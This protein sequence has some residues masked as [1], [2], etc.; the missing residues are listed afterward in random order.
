M[1]EYGLYNGAWTGP[2]IDAAIGRS[3]QISNPNLLD[4]WYFVGGGSQNGYGKFPINQRRATTYNNITSLQYGADR[5]YFSAGSYELVAQGMKIDG[6]VSQF[7]E[8]DRAPVDQGYTVSAL[9]S[10]GTFW[11]NSAVVT[12][13]STNL[14]IQAGENGTNQVG[15]KGMSRPTGNLWQVVVFNNNASRYLVAVKLERGAQQTLAHRENNVWRLNEIPDF[16]QELAKCQRYLT[17]FYASAASFI[18]L[19]YAQSTSTVR[20]TLNLPV[21][22]LKGT[23]T[24]RTGNVPQV[25][26]NASGATRNPSACSLLEIVGNIAS[27]EVTVSGATVGEFDRIIMP[28]GTYFGISN[29]L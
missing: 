19:G 18:A 5:W 11:T 3:A 4:N 22:M 15:L 26:Y 21:P 14:V 8:L 12:A 10:D 23:N 16:Q 2:E 6:A 7:F 28:S 20:F 29:E 25:Y 9:F 13:W 17:H 24:I 1:P 27:F